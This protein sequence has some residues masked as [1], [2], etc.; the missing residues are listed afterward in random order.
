MISFSLA[1]PSSCLL[2]LKL[3]FP[4][5]SLFLSGNL[6]EITPNCLSVGRSLFD[7]PQPRVLDI[8]AGKSLWVGLYP[9]VRAAWKPFLNVDMANKPGEWNE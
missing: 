1:L 8:G 9:S 5:F 2:H 6:H 3:V 7:F 4:F